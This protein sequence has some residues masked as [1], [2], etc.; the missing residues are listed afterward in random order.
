MGRKGDV[1]MVKLSDREAREKKEAEEWD[2]EMERSI[3]IN[4]FADSNREFF[5]VLMKDPGKLKKC[6]QILKLSNK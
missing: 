2:E 1:I 3:R 5:E 4:L 6:R